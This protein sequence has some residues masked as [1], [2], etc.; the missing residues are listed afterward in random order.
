MTSNRWD[1][2]LSDSTWYVPAANR[3]AYQ[4]DSTTADPAPVSDQTI[5]SIGQAEGGRFTGYSHATIANPDGGTNSSVTTMDGVV[6]E[7][8]QVRITF[9]NPVGS[10]VTGIGQ[11]RRVNGVEAI[12]MQMIAS[13]NGGY[14][15]HW[16]Y[17]LPVGDS[18]TPP[19]PATDLGDQTSYLSTKYQWLQGTSWNFNSLGTR[20]NGLFTITGYRK[21]YFWGQGLERGSNESLEV[22][23]SITPEGNFF[24]NAI[25]K[26]DFELRF[27][28]VGLLWGPSP[29]AK[30]Q[31]R[32]YT[33]NQ[34]QF[35]L[36]LSLQ[37]SDA[38]MGRDLI[39]EGG[40]LP[41]IAS[42]F[43]GANSAIETVAGLEWAGAGGLVPSDREWNG[44]DG[45]LA[46]TGVF[47]D[48]GARWLSF[49]GVEPN[50]NPIDPWL[51]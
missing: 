5:W 35:D 21:G 28:Q 20:T 42:R 40:E 19:D 39:T 6:T 47:S 48:P 15:T 33:N 30:A 7:S 14:T 4:L 17:M 22:L 46:A 2:L 49:A 38:L 51:S 50:A 44:G 31:L 29:K 16:A 37:R 23:G 18:T 26:D 12:E 24:V 41:A 8:G 10:T 27:S 3:L 34:D 9:T 25:D 45:I 43:G 32:P 1:Q 11:V 36:P 13:N